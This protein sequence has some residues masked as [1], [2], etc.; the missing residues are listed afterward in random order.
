MSL[1]A[2]QKPFEACTEPAAHC[3]LQLLQGSRPV[4]LHVREA[5]QGSEHALVTAFHP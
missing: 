4:E 1:V 2:V 3:A 5:V